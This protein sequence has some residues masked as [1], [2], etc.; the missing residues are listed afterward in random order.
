M[1]REEYVYS[2]IVTSSSN[3]C[4]YQ[5]F[6][7]PFGV[8]TTYHREYTISEAVYSDEELEEAL[9][10]KFSH[11][12]EKLQEKGIQIIENNVTITIN[13]DQAQMSGNCF[14]HRVRMRQGG[15][16]ELSIIENVLDIP[17]STAVTFSE[18]VMPM[19]RR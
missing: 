3:L 8:D 1:Y 4:V 16:W 15:C 18:A 12:L 11:Y 9:N 10:E 5:N 14:C 13:D 19:S 17:A 2:D 6:Y 7:L